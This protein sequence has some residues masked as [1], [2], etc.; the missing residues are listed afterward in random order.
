MQAVGHDVESLHVK[1]LGATLSKEEILKILVQDM[2]EGAIDVDWRDFFPYLKWVPNNRLE[3]RLKRLVF[4][5][6]AVMDALISEAKKRIASGEVVSL[7]LSMNI[8]F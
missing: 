6:K 7:A 3:S 5:R 4:C 8:P 1:E 2:M